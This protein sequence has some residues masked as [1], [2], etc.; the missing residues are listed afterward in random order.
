LGLR[1][2]EVGKITIA[3]MLPQALRRIGATYRVEPIPWGDYVL[4]IECTVRDAKGY[5]VRMRCARRGL[6]QATKAVEHE[7]LRQSGREETCQI[8]NPLS[9]PS[10]G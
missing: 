9:A 4:G 1:E 10:N 7:E 3:P 6:K 5:T 8:L 2:E